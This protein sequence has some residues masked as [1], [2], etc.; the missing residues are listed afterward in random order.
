MQAKSRCALGSADFSSLPD[1][2]DQGNSRHEHPVVSA[3]RRLVQSASIRSDESQASVVQHLAQLYDR[4]KEYTGRLAEYNQEVEKYELAR[5]A[6]LQHLIKEH[7]QKQEQLHEEQLQ[8]QQNPSMW[9]RLTEG[10]PSVASWM[11]ETGNDD[12][13]KRKSKLL[14]PAQRQ[15]L[16]KV[17]AEQQVTAEMGPGPITPAAPKGLYLWGSVGSGKTMIMVGLSAYM[18][19]PDPV[20]RV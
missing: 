8:A 11:T 7:E 14:T 5:S 2:H 4:L 17:A 16:A 9:S 18:G 12:D 13:S 6:R 1:V 20:C 15:R 19:A 3:Y 10:V